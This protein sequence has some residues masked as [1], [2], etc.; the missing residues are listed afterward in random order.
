MF[1]SLKQSTDESFNQFILKLRI[2]ATRCDFRDREEKEILHQVTMGARDERVKDN[3]T[4]YAINREILIKQ[5]E[6]LYS[7]KHESEQAG[8]SAVKQVWVKKSQSKPRNPAMRTFERERPWN[9]DNRARLEC[10]RCGSWK[11]HNGSESCIARNSRCNNCG[12]IGHFA[13]KCRSV[14]KTQFRARST[15]KRNG[16][17]TNVLR[18]ENRT[19]EEP[20]R[21]RQTSEESMNVE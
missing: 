16:G 19:D 20:I 17:E 18:E 21:R 13:R 7:F 1:R 9:K 14:R 5:K 6:K 11:H 8:V 2:Q 4:N 12:R 3:L 15:W 10:D